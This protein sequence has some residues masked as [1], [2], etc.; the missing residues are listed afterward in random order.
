MA[1]LAR[2]PKSSILFRS[3]CAA[4]MGRNHPGEVA[5]K[6]LDIRPRPVTM[7]VMSTAIVLAIVAVVMLLG[8]GMVANQLLRLKRYLNESPA[9]TT[10]P[11]EP[12]DVR[13]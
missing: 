5:R 2:P 4:P 6:D 9:S 10:P 1:S 8:I 7:G 13:R 12:P 3:Q 11:E